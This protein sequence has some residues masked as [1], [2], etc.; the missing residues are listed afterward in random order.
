MI[1]L[2]MFGFLL[3]TPGKRVEN[4]I[5]DLRSNG[6]WMQHGWL[7]DDAW[8][9]RY[10]REKSKFRNDAK[11]QEVAAL[12]KSHGVNYI[13]PHLCPCKAD[14]TIAACDTVQTARFLRHFSDFKVIPWIGGVFEKQCYPSSEQWRSR[15]VTST[16]ALLEAHPGLAGVQINIEP[17]PSGNPGFLKLLTELKEQL[18]EGKILSIAAYPPPTIWQ[19]SEEVHWDE[20]YFREV[21]KRVD[22]VAPMMYDTGIRR[23]KLYQQLMAKWTREILLWSEDT[24]VLLGLPAYDDTGVGYHDPKIE[25]LENGILGINAGLGKFKNLPKNY[26]G[27]AIYS[28]WE[29][30]DAKWALFECE[31][32]G[33]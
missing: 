15:F 7:G 31:F 22:Q 12:L 32:E 1:T 20:T 2:L 27:V 9:E 10:K 14:G 6:I 13:F 3:W 25:N 23:K 29:M 26:A 5:Y 19:P 11:I 17:M 8:F 33:K 16:L 4:G 18:P 28:E 21:A 30:D 24:E